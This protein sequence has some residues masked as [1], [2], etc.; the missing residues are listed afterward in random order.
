M[1]QVKVMVV[2]DDAFTRFTLISTLHLSNFI[3]VAEANNSGEAIIKAEKFKPDVVLLDLDLGKG[4]TGV[5]LAVA[6]RNKYP[7]IG[8]VILTS[9]S[10]PRLH[11]SS[12][13]DLPSG[14][15]FLVKQDIS[16]PREIENKVLASSQNPVG[17]DSVKVPNKFE[18]SDTQIETLRLVAQGLS[19]LEIAKQRFVTE[20]SVELTISRVAK[21]L[22]I[23]RDQASNQRVQLVKKVLELT[24]KNY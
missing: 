1:T 2:E 3:V 15:I 10:D 6:L 18:L 23:S 21:K 14:S 17:I 22:G 16:N 8:I 12:I 13:P 11:R 24:G 4:P 7:K 19:N 9:Y 5:D 20:K